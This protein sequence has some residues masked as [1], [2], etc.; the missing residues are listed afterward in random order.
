MIADGFDRVR[1][2]HNWGVTIARTESLVVPVRW[3]GVVYITNT[4][5]GVTHDGKMWGVFSTTE[6]ELIIRT[7]CDEFYYYSYTHTGIRQGNNWFLFHTSTKSLTNYFG[8]P[9]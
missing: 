4:L 3:K 8:A 1:Y 7:T 5:W 9:L 2:G 6:Q